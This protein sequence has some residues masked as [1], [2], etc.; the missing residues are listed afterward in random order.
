MVDPVSGSGPV[1]GASP[2]QRAQGNNDKPK[3]EETAR[4]NPQDEV[5]ISS[6]ALSQQQAEQIARQTSRTLSGSQ[7]SLGLDPG[8]DTSA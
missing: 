7:Y 8:F 3:A 5:E 1:Q 4:A 6:E 2:V